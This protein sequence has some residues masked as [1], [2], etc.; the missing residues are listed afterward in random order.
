MNRVVE[1]GRRVPSI[2]TEPCKQLPPFAYDDY[3]ARPDGKGE[4]ATRHKWHGAYRGPE[5]Q[6]PISRLENNCAV[7]YTHPE[8]FGQIPQMVDFL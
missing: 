2:S 5:V 6:I 7:W 1:S 4:S 3:L 8:F